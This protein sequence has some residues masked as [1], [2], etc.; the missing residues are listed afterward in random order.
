MLLAISAPKLAQSQSLGLQA[1]DRENPLREGKRLL[2]VADVKVLGFHPHWMNAQ[3][4][5]QCAVGDDGVS[6]K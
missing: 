4:V 1:K 5:L 6:P 2:L 3:V